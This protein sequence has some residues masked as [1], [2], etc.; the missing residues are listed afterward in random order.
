MND[1]KAKRPHLYSF[2]LPSGQYVGRDGYTG[3]WKPTGPGD[4]R[5]F[6]ADEAKGKVSFFA[7]I[8]TAPLKIVPA[9]RWNPESG[10]YE[11]PINVPDL[12]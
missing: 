9:P 8:F 1:M 4:A 5:S 6:K 12:N 11:T 2:Q 3:P 10:E 7:S